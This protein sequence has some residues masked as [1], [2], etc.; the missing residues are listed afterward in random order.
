MNEF[1]Y[2]E[3]SRAHRGVWHL[4]EGEAVRTIVPEK[5]TTST[6]DI[7]DYHTDKC[8][9]N[10]RTYDNRTGQYR[11]GPECDCGHTGDVIG[12]YTSVHVSPEHETIYAE[13]VACN[14]VGRLR[15][16]GLKWRYSSY[17]TKRKDGDVERI[18]DGI[19]KPLYATGDEF[20]AGPW[21]SR[22]QAKL[23]KRK[24]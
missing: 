20:P 9:L 5:V 1:I 7:R 23:D 11:A 21:C 16:G 15:T 17:R 3:G 10:V 8:A 14:Q 18:V 22:C 13:K 2:N 6:R 24:P 4:V 19:E 12:H